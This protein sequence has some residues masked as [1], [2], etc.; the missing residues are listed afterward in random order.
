MLARGAYLFKPDED[1]VSS[2]HEG[3]GCVGLQMF[4]SSAA[5]SLGIWVEPLSP[6]LEGFKQLWIPALRL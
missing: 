2:V 3:D 4:L 5:Q 6:L 1:S